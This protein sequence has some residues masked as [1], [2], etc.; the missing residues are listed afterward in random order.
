MSKLPWPAAALLTAPPSDGA[1]GMLTRPSG[2]LELPLLL[3]GDDAGLGPAAVKGWASDDDAG[4]GAA[5]VK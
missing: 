2:S 5:A 3:A 4:L 1:A